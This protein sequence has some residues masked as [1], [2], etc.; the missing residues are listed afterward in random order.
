LDG[1]RTHPG[2]LTADCQKSTTRVSVAIP[3]E[4]ELD[5]VLIAVANLEVV[6]REVEVRHGL[7]LSRAAVTRAAEVIGRFA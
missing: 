7:A 1:N 2:R 6:G 4:A 5:H 3:D